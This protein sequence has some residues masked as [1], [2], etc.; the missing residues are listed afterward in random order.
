RHRN[1][2]RLPAPDSAPYRPAG[3]NTHRLNQPHPRW[4]VAAVE[5][6][7][8]THTPI[9]GESTCQPTT[10][11]RSSSAAPLAPCRSLTSSLRRSL[12]SHPSTSF[13]DLTP[14]RATSR[15]LRH[16]PPTTPTPSTLRLGI[17]SSPTPPATLSASTAWCSATP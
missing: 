10:T 14:V 5:A 3:R 13:P 1:G 2:T 7:G 9:Q 11:G 15:G 4:P 16:Q 17:G 12:I 6:A 8:L